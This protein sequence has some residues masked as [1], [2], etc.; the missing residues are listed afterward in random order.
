VRVGMI[1]CAHPARAAPSSFHF[2]GDRFARE[3]GHHAVPQGLLGGKRALA[4]PRAFRPPVGVARMSG[5]VRAVHAQRREVTAFE[6]GPAE[7]MRDSLMP[8]QIVAGAKGIELRWHLAPDVP[9]RVR[10]KFLGLSEANVGRGRGCRIS[11]G[12]SLPT[13]ALLESQS[14]SE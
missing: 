10:P 5:S 7:L 3:S 2:V 8:L 9:V 11:R 13:S 1:E 14:N 6:F 12:V 4:L